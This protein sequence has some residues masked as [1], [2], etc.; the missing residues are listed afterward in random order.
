MSKVKVKDQTSSAW[1][2]FLDTATNI[3]IIPILVLSV[4]CSLIMINA[5]K[6]N[7]VPNIF[8]Y[9]LVTVLSESMEK[10][11]FEVDD[12]VVVKKVDT[13]DIAIGDVIA[14]YK[15]VD[16]DV[17]SAVLEQQYKQNMLAESIISEKE[18]TGTALSE[19]TAEEKRIAEAYYNSSIA[20]SYS[21]VDSWKLELTKLFS[22]FAF[23]PSEAYARAIKVNSPI[24]FHQ[25]VQ[26]VDYN[27]S[28]WFRTWGTTNV[29]KATGV[30]DYDSYWIN[31]DYVVG[32]YVNTGKAVRSFLA[33]SSTNMGIVWMVEVPSGL[34]LILSTLE[35]IEIIDI[36]NKMKQEQIKNGTYINRKEYKRMLREKRKLMK[37]ENI[38]QS[39]IK[40]REAPYDNFAVTK[41]TAREAN[42]NATT[43]GP[44]DEVPADEI[45][46]R[47]GK[48]QSSDSQLGAYKHGA[49]NRDGP[50]VRDKGGGDED[51]GK[52]M[53]V[54][55]NQ[56]ERVKNERETAE[57]IKKLNDIKAALALATESPPAEHQEL[58]KGEVKLTADEIKK[59]KDRYEWIDMTFVSDAEIT[60]K[61]LLPSPSKKNKIYLIDNKTN[62]EYSVNELGIVHSV[63][64]GLV[65]TNTGV[66]V[67]SIG[68][69]GVDFEKI[70][71]DP[72][73]DLI[74]AKQDA[75]GNIYIGI[76]G[77][78][79]EE[80]IVTTKSG[81]RISFWNRNALLALGDDRRLYFLAMD[82]NYDLAKGKVK[83]LN[84]LNNKGKLV[85]IKLDK[86]RKVVFED[87]FKKY[88]FVS[89]IGNKLFLEG[90]NRLYDLEQNLYVTVPQDVY[91]LDDNCFVQLSKNKTLQKID[92]N[93]FVK[94][95]A[96][97]KTFD[98][99]EPKETIAT[100]VSN[101]D[102][103]DNTLLMYKSKE[104]GKKVV[105]TLAPARKA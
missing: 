14:Y 92:A 31:E 55:L 69:D 82:G 97:G 33:F 87:S 94:A 47:N 17:S 39:T 58:K 66:Y 20:P 16:T 46:W 24:I 38:D 36:M 76:V 67:A 65:H 26:I 73:Y 1:L 15:F 70:E 91:L 72:S 57:Q 50:P 96:E 40:R 85:G 28:R 44:P 34:H 101:F 2:R 13:S 64:S 41:Q 22:K 81:K 6:Q 8:G 4:V 56:G 48:G 19:A 98:E 53:I 80:Q 59:L 11:G 103:K 104:S 43:N 75:F 45:A 61:G 84:V 18:I 21:R 54:T 89:L 86:K 29:N 74:S 88:G 52:K 90:G 12:T 49:S 35:L 62:R 9:S 37:S 83:S 10:S 100:E 51:Y 102:V 63:G 7:N 42:L 32:K 27:G 68:E 60:N 30:P 23:T 79:T 99:A 95:L 5:K 93:A 78:P 105:I 77:G 3:I 71:I 25:V